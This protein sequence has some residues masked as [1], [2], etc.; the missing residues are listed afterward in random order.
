MP[1]NEDLIS[2]LINYL[3]YQPCPIFSKLWCFHIL[4][5]IV[6]FNVSVSISVNVNVNVNQCFC[7]CFLDS[8]C[9]CEIM[10]RCHCLEME[11]W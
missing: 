2:Y 8:K 9:F 10:I 5:Y 4:S 7:P 1:V 3:L 11:L 6:C